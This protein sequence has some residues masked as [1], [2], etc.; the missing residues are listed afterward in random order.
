[1]RYVR[2]A[3]KVMMQNDGDFVD[4]ILLYSA[5]S[6]E[7][8]EPD[9]LPSSQQPATGSYPERRLRRV[10]IRVEGEKVWI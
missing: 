7:L 1:M 5:N 9:L 8:M 4:Q 10:N 6:P 3:L 2:L